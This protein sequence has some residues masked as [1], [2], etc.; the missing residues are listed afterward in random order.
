MSNEKHRSNEDNADVNGPN[1]RH[2]TITAH[3]TS[4]LIYYP[5]LAGGHDNKFAQQLNP[6]SRLT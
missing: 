3:S 5:R 1:T 2:R 6:T 4:L